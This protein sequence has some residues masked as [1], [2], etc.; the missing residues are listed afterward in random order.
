MLGAR[1]VVVRELADRGRHIIGTE[2]ASIYAVHSKDL[3]AGMNATY[4]S[5]AEVVQRGG[6]YYPVLGI[7]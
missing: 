3:I 7:N 6:D 1:R 2:D 4:P 5:S